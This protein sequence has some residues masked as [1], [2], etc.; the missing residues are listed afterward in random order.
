ML[1][2]LLQTPTRLRVLE[3]GC[4]VG[5]V[6][7]SLGRAKNCDVIL[8]DLPEAQEIVERN[9]RA[10][11]NPEPKTESIFTFMP[12][13]WE[14]PLPPEVKRAPVDLILVADCT[15]NADSS[16]SLT[17]TLSR[18][19]KLSPKAPVVVA[20]KIRHPSELIFFKL[21]EG[22]GLAQAYH[23]VLHLPHTGEEDPEIVDVYTF[24]RGEITDD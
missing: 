9:I 2:T 6:G 14:N 16:P 3:L 22:F 21:M 23:H 1:N 5:I 10:N 18:L 11:S 19:L 17:K 7:I 12:L 24:I 4:G 13:S 8:T 15:Y 20:M